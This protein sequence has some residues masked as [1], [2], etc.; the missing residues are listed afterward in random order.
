MPWPKR[1]KA[2]L[3]AAAALS[4]LA[5]TSVGAQETMTATWCLS[6][7]TWLMRVAERQCERC[8]IT[9]RH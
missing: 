2:L 7:A 3:L 4:A 5:R 9:L 1:A 6:K 8:R